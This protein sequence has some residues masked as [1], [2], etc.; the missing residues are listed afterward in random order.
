MQ[1][2]NFASLSIGLFFLVS[3]ISL[4]TLMIMF[5]FVWQPI[6]TEGFK[7][8]HAISDAIGKLN[9]TA[10]PSAEIAPDMLNEIIRMRKSMSHME[11]TMQTMVEIRSI[12]TGMSESMKKLEEINPNIVSINHSVDLMGRT[13]SGQLGVMNY[14]VNQ[15]SDRFSPMGM[16]MP[17]NW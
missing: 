17:F 5:V 3:S 1:A 11:G 12:M 6:W 2:K 15:M 8:F 7:D 10:K 13:M 14:E 9:E 16:M 4:A